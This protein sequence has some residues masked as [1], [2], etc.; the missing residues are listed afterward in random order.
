MRCRCERPGPRC[1]QFPHR[2]CDGARTR[3]GSEF[4]LTLWGHVAL[5]Q[6]TVPLRGAS[7]PALADLSLHQIQPVGGCSSLHGSRDRRPQQQ[8]PCTMTELPSGLPPKI[9]MRSSGTQ[10]VS[11]KARKRAKQEARHL[12]EARQAQIITGDGRSGPGGQVRPHRSSRVAGIR[13]RR[14]GG[15]MS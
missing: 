11:K 8:G 14:G 5:V 4:R 7:V 10:P 6:V 13:G 2:P 9:L 3:P 15:R 12:E 1:A